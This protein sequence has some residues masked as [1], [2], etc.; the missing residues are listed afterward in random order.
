ML[1]YL[2]LVPNWNAPNGNFFE[3]LAQEIRRTSYIAEVYTKNNPTILEKLALKIV[4]R[5]L[6]KFSKHDK[7][8]EELLHFGYHILAVKI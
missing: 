1:E 3:Y 7:G 8:S 2:C 6:E 5:M 4:L